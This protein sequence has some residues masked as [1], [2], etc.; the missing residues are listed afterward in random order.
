M[1]PQSYLDAHHEQHNDSSIATTS[2]T[3]EAYNNSL[4]PEGSGSGITAEQERSMGRFAIPTSS[5]SSKDSTLKS[6][7]DIVV[8][9]PYLTLRG[10]G[11]DVEATHLTGHVVLFLTEA[12]SMKEVYLEFRGKAKIP[13]P[14][15]ESLIGNPSSMLAYNVCHHRWSFLEL[16]T[17]SK[18]VGTRTLKAGRHIFPFSLEIGGSL[19][20]SI[21]TPVLGGA[22]VSYKLYAEAS[23]PHK[24]NFPFSSNLHHTVPITL[25]RSFAQTALEYQ[26]TLEIENTW[27]GKLMYSIVLP[28]KAWAQGD[29]LGVLVKFSPTVKGVGVHSILTNVEEKTRIYARS[30]ERED[31]RVVASA[32]HEIVD[33][34]RAVLVEATNKPA[35]WIGHAAPP[36]SPPP[37]S[38][39]EEV[40]R[41]LQREREESL[42]ASSSS[43]GL[44]SQDS[45]DTSSF[46][47]DDVS[48]IAPT[49]I[50][51]TLSLPLPSNSTAMIPSHALEP[52][53]VSHRVRWAIYITNPDGHISELRCSL[54]IIIMDGRLL[55]ETRM[56]T[57]FTRRSVLSP[58][59]M[60]AGAMGA[61]GVPG[62]EG[63]NLPGSEREPGV[64]VLDLDVEDQELPS[65]HAHVRDRV[66][67]MYLP[68]SSTLRVTNPWVINGTSPTS[69]MNSA[70]VSRNGEA[71]MSLM[72]LTGFEEA[73]SGMA[74]PVPPSDA[75]E[76]A[77]M[78][79]IPSGD[80]PRGAAMS[81]PASSSL[82][83]PLSR[84][85]SRQGS[86]PSA[87]PSSLAGHRSSFSSSRFGLPGSR[88]RSGY[89]TPLE[90]AHVMAHLPH[91]PGSGDNTPLDWVNSE[92]LLSLSDE[93]GRRFEREIELSRGA[94]GAQSL[95][96]SRPS[97]PVQGQSSSSSSRPATSQGKSGL[98][99]F[100]KGAIKGLGFTKAHR[101]DS[102]HRYGQPS[103]SSQ[104]T[105]PPLPPTSNTRQSRP[106][107][108]NVMRMV[109]SAPVSPRL[110]PIALVNPASHLPRTGSSSS[111][112]SSV[113]PRTPITPL[114]RPA[115]PNHLRDCPYQGEQ[116]YCRENRDE[117]L[118]HRAFTEVPDYSVAARGFIGGVAPLSSL[119]GL[120]S[121]EEAAR[122]RDR[123][124]R[125]VHSG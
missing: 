79:E 82:G 42:R 37:L 83:L 71:S 17:G 66:A 72:S 115:S 48:P 120:P 84:T 74:G 75:D 68:E 109:A 78:G 52:V 125:R 123:E 108:S 104:S 43:S 51:T 45:F 87:T 62:W 94:S 105:G 91:A 54:P 88:P 65:Y 70:A 35:L 61:G 15:S 39:V 112:S 53:T 96:P 86:L 89:N 63:D 36:R 3:N 23:R 22:S 47:S 18:H 25:I 11:P 116:P 24:L 90:P 118:L 19:P 103:S 80:A 117:H 100:L 2:A 73:S 58:E 40:E 81:R 113:S 1:S 99:G 85:H 121:Y 16:G 49:D 5:R 41:A 27:P 124:Q 10:T 60:L 9:S 33:G 56:Y 44:R 107:S 34:K 102:E 57:A 77:E 119:L 122:D 28:H 64:D 114:S 50:V 69:P 7:I 95:V 59:G 31:K 38:P 110:R 12:T 21:S 92:L 4:Q 101:D 20:S 13:V 106:S 26:Q 46:D 30:G 29:T 14:A 8:D 67:N 76:G 6:Y 32:R 55:N 93:P 111:I 98:G 97:S